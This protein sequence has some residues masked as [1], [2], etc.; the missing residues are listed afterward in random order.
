[1]GMHLSLA[2][3]PFNVD[4]VLY[5]APACGGTVVA[6]HGSGTA[7]IV[8]PVCEY[9][10][11]AALF[12]GRVPQLH[13]W[14]DANAE[15]RGGMAFRKMQNVADLKGEVV[16]RRAR[17][18]QLRIMADSC[19]DRIRKRF[20]ECESITMSVDDSKRRKVIRYRC[21]RAVAI[22]ANL[23]FLNHGSYGAL[24]SLGFG[25]LAPS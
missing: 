13:D 21:D 4:G 20:R 24:V 11:D 2:E 9:T 8:K 1:M 6:E 22:L 23:I 16:D 14:V 18:K 7:S 12:K 5:D 19:R 15:I 10:I 3:A 17:V 25:P